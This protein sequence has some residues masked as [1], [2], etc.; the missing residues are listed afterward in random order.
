MTD[1]S[2]HLHMPSYQIFVESI[3]VLALPI[4]GSEL[5]GIM[6]AYLCAGETSKGD[7]YLRALIKHQA[8][9]GL[10]AAASALFEL[11]A[12]S[13]Q[14]ITHFDFEF[15][16]LLPDDDQSLVERAKAFSEWCEGFTQGLTLVGVGF[17][18]LEEEEAQEALQHLTEFAQLDHEALHVEE[19]DEHSFMEISEYARLAVL[20]I[21]EDLYSSH[22]KGGSSQTAH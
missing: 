1:D 17:D 4:S 22:F 13:Q 3:A 9:E 16:L 5:H 11:Y 8:V 6:C 10:R 21:Y 20:R 15:Q 19:D 7:T 12:V 18:E 2:H 14:Q